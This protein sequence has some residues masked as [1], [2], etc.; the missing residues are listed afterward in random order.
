MERVN[1]FG[2]PDCPCIHVYSTSLIGR[3]YRQVQ[4]HGVGCGPGTSKF[5]LHLPSTP[6]HRAFME[7]PHFTTVPPF[8]N[9]SA[10]PQPWGSCGTARFHNC[11]PFHNH[12]RFHNRPPVPQPRA[13]PQPPAVP[14]P[15]RGAAV[16]QPPGERCSTTTRW[17]VER[18]GCGSGGDVLEGGGR[19]ATR[20]AFQKGWVGFQMGG[21]ASP[22]TPRIRI[23]RF[24]IWPMYVRNRILTSDVHM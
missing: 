18:G 14:Q 7:P 2:A 9:N 4:N 12:D 15:A 5:T 17:V 22:H 11:P 1:R 3:T 19:S 24:A 20:A 8:H 13:V 6:N 23:F 16:P 21:A 10:V